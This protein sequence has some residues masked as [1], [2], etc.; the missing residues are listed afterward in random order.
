MTHHLFL[1]L[2][3]C[4]AILSQV[5]CVWSMHLLDSENLDHNVLANQYRCYLALFCTILR[6]WSFSQ[7]Q[8]QVFWWWQLLHLRMLLGHW[9]LGNSSRYC[10]LVPRPSKCRLSW[11]LSCQTSLPVS[12]SQT[13]EFQRVCGTQLR[14]G[15]EELVAFRLWMR[16]FRVWHSRS[17]VSAWQQTSCTDHHMA[18]R[19]PWT[20]CSSAR[21]LGLSQNRWWLFHNLFLIDEQR[22]FP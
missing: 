20:L 8:C 2:H 18:A 17:L 12:S 3:L 11:M 14:V 6:K 22:H 9:V 4:A 10:M 5:K 15:A 1:D 21:C 19:P 13:W 16:V 7:R